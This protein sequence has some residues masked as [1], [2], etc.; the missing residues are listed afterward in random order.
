MKSAANDTGIPVPS[1]WEN[2]SIYLFVSPTDDDAAFAGNVSVVRHIPE[3]PMALEQVVAKLPAA[4][5]GNAPLVL[6]Q[7]FKR[8]GQSP[9]FER[10]SRFVDDDSGALLQQ[11]QRVVMWRRQPIIVTYTHQADAFAQD[12]GIVDD[13][14]AAL[15]SP[16][17]A[18]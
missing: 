14:F 16:G 10:V 11:L 9:Y 18:S 8:A 15:V 5:G 7:G 2:R 4:G 3:K 6:S 17:G 1:H 13:M 12:Q